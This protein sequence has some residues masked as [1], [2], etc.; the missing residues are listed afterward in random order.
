MVA[1]RRNFLRKTITYMLIGALTVTT[2]TS[3]YT[4][5][6][7]AEVETTHESGSHPSGDTS[8]NP[9]TGSPDN[10]FDLCKNSW[11]YLCTQLGFFVNDMCTFDLN[12]IGVGALDNTDDFVEY[13]KGHNMTTDDVVESYDESAGTVNLSINYVKNVYNDVLDA[14]QEDEGWYWSSGKKGASYFKKFNEVNYNALTELAN[15]SEYYIIIP[16]IQKDDDIYTMVKDKY[17]MRFVN[18]KYNYIDIKEKSKNLQ[19]ETVNPASGSFTDKPF[20][21]TNKYILGV[22]EGSNLS[23]WS[24]YV[25]NLQYMSGRYPTGFYNHIIPTDI[26][27]KLYLS[28]SHESDST[29]YIKGMPDTNVYLYLGLYVDTINFEQYFCSHFIYGPKQRIYTD[30]T[31]LNQMM[32]GGNVLLES[33][34]ENISSISIKLDDLNRDWLKVNTE[35]KDL[36]DDYMKDFQDYT[37][38]QDK[39]DA[40]ISSTLATM[41]ENLAAGKEDLIG[42]IKESAAVQQLWLERIY[43]KEVEIY[44]KYLEENEQTQA[45][46]VGIAN[47]LKEYFEASLKNQ[48]NY[49]TYEHFAAYAQQI[50]DAINNSGGSSGTGTDGS[51]VDMSTVD[52]YIK[53]IY[54]KEV[55]LYDELQAISKKLD[56]INDNLTKYLW[57]TDKSIPFLADIANLIKDGF[58]KCSAPLDILSEKLDELINLAKSILAVL[59]LNTLIDSLDRT[60]SDDEEENASIFTLVKMIMYLVLILG[61]LVVL[62]LKI[63]QYIVLMFQIPAEPAL[64]NENILLGWN[65][66]NSICIPGTSFSIIAFLRLLMYITVI[67]TVVKVLRREINNGSIGVIK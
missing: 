61:S 7:F 2:F 65:Y 17:Y 50:I 56:N 45:V 38:K 47:Q 36:I 41:N 5:S 64:F 9:Y 20:K 3:I 31:S 13:L 52:E 67:F 33:I 16:L 59:S 18:S 1:I 21:I 10:V 57:N 53:K 58:E 23:N 25:A 46:L 55:N 37:E 26:R 22:Y 4:Q 32:N 12:S 51:A 44:T 29:R 24:N 14:V 66:A 39:I 19:F 11:M 54:E 6:V 49:L 8:D 43:N 35:I 34:N 15:N 30:K 28:S 60:K 63:L 62:F 27:Y 40:A 48:G 42:A